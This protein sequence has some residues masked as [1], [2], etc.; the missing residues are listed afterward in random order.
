M[1]NGSVQIF[2]SSGASLEMCKIKNWNIYQTK[3]IRC[4]RNVGCRYED[5]KLKTGTFTKQN[6]YDVYEMLDV[7]TED[8]KLK[9]G[10]FTPK[11]V[12]GM[13]DVGTTDTKL[14]TGIFT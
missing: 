8:T 9:T 10:T 7:G 14:K 4:I 3:C 1:G 6:V 5:T 2:A 13:L 11:N 12:Y